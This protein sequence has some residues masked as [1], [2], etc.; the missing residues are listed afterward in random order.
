LEFWN[1][2]SYMQWTRVNVINLFSLSREVEIIIH[3]LGTDISHL[4]TYYEGNSA[5][6]LA[7]RVKLTVEHIWFHC[8]SIILCYFDLYVWIVFWKSHHVQQ[9]MSSQILDF[10]VKFKCMFDLSLNCFH[11]SVYRF[12]IIN[13]YPIYQ[14]LHCSYMLNVPVL[15][16]SQ[17]P[18][19]LNM[20]HMFCINY[21]WY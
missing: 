11:S 16:T 8:V 13:V 10:I 12:R 21:S 18:I 19:V 14:L 4:D 9:L 1:S 17:I 2:T 7:Y 15:A 5:L 20:S 6:V 3:R